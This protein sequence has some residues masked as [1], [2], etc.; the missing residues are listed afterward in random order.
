MLHHKE[1][2]DAA[3][4]HEAVRL[5]IFLIE[6]EESSRPLDNHT[7]TCTYDNFADSYLHPRLFPS[8][9]EREKMLAELDLTEEERR[10]VVRLLETQLAA[11]C[12]HNYYPD[13]TDKVD[14]LARRKRQSFQSLLLNTPPLESLTQ[15]YVH[16]SG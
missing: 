4:H 14:D 12:A 10:F 16:V 15:M 2:T 3:A 5:Q 11:W 13:P 1:D 8:A 9:R 7:Q 6:I